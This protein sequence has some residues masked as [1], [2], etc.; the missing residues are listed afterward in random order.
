MGKISR[1]KGTV[2]RS[3]LIGTY[4]VGAIVAVKDESFMIAGL[5]EWSVGSPDIHEPRL[6]EQLHVHGFNAPPAYVEERDTSIPVVR[7][8]RYYSCP[9]CH[10]LDLFR[11]FNPMGENKCPTCRVDLVPSRFVVAC[12]NGHVDDF[13]YW[14]WVHRG[15]KPVT[16]D[17]GTRHE[18]TIR[19]EGATGALRDIVVRCSCGKASTLHGAFN[20]GAM[21]GIISCTGNRPWLRDHEECT[22]IPRT[23][24]RGASNVYFPITRSSL[25]IPPWSQG[26]M[27]TL[28]S[29]WQTLRVI[30]DAVLPTVI[31]GMNLAKETGYSV[32]MLV[33]AV[34][35]RRAAYAAAAD[36][37]ESGDEALRP[38]EYKALCIGRPEDSPTDDFVCIPA[39]IT[40]AVRTWFE[41]VML[42]TRL[43]EVRVLTAFTRLLPPTPSDL[44]DPADGQSVGRT[45]RLAKEQ[46]DWLP[47]IEVNGEGVFFH[48]DAVRL[49]EWEARPAVQARVVP[50]AEHYRASLFAASADPE[51][52]ISPRLV[53]IH[54]LAHALINQWSLAS[55][56]PAA[57]LRERLYVSD[58]M[59]GLLI[60]TA[61][62]DAAGSMGGVVSLAGPKLLADALTEAVSRAAWCSADPLCMEADATGV[63]SLNLAA[64]H[65]CVLLPETSCEERNTLLDRALLVGTP[66]HPEIGFFSALLLE[67]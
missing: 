3:Q 40:S 11:R 37:E 10:R 48:L 9:T 63:D 61:T 28:N 47:A 7:F 1:N 56:Y 4:G 51:R 24:Q 5:D 23:L 55:G 58:E 36:G 64:C 18:L 8:P 34:K 14:E 52:E 33:M 17:Y 20:K 21:K 39:G 27:K 32:E 50:I 15:G 62:S 60:Y 31:E 6:E 30:P 35:E 25:S 67:A 42:V 43:R 54:T 49:S 53:M 45:A 41:A 19:T 65:A 57:S 66:E 22:E 44:A 2:R 46:T 29:Q 26:V 12:A 59:A 16:G 13:P 38:A